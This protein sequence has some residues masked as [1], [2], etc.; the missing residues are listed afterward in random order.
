MLGVVA[1]GVVISYLIADPRIA[2]ASVVAF[3][4][5][6][7]LDFVVYTPIRARS[8]LGDRRWA[9]AVTASSIVGA[10]ADTILF[11]AIAFGWAAV[12]PALA[13]QMLGKLWATLAYLIVGK[14]GSRALLRES[15]RPARA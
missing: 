5:A 10:L 1:L 9:G 15:V 13:G 8:R 14:V 3:A 4:A 7:I 11:L 2:L 6:E 12:L